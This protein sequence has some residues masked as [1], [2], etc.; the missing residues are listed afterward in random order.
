[1]DDSFSFNTNV[2]KSNFLLSYT[3]FLLLS[4]YYSL[5]DPDLQILKNPT[6]VQQCVKVLDLEL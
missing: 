4:I 3:N 2:Q 6:N 1:M 5:Y